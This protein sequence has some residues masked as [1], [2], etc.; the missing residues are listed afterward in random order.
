MKGLLRR[1]LLF[2]LTVFLFG[3]AGCGSAVIFS[4]SYLA[5]IEIEP[6]ENGQQSAR[7]ALQKFEGVAMPGCKETTQW[8][9]FRPC[10]EVLPKAYSTLSFSDL[11]TGTLLLGGLTDVKITQ[12]FATGTAAKEAMESD[13]AVNAFYAL[14]GEYCP[15]AA[16]DCIEAWIDAGDSERGGAV[17]KWWEAQG[18]EG[19]GILRLA[20]CGFDADRKAFIEENDIQC[21]P[22]LDHADDD[23]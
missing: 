5:G 17:Q 13:A 21:D 18:N 22:P 9:S 10:E 16:M 1:G 23:G 11:D 2:P 8:W 12:V 19:V 20:S 7:V 14:E 6:G 3:S 4:T 15:D